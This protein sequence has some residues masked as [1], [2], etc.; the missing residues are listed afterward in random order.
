MSCDVGGMH[1]NRWLTIVWN[2][3]V[4]IKASD[5]GF[6]FTPLWEVQVK[7]D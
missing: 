2:S 4:F 1:K 5:A 3:F 6:S 7:N